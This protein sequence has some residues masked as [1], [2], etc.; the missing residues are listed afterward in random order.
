ML[1]QSLNEGSCEV[2]LSLQLSFSFS[3]IKVPALRREFRYFIGRA[4]LQ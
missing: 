1:A 3:L 4:H 2:Y